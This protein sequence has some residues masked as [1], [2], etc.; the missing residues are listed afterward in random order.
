MDDIVL[1]ES[2]EFLRRIAGVVLGDADGT[3]DDV[4]A[5]DN[6]GQAT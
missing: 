6:S 3:S 1:G 2:G 4:A 5:E